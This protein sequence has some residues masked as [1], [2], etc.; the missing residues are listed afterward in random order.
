ML[1]RKRA[2]ARIVKWLR[3][4]RRR[5]CRNCRHF[6]EHYITGLNDQ[7]LFRLGY[8]QNRVYDCRLVEPDI[9]RRCEWFEEK[10]LDYT[11]TEFN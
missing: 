8:C 3:S 4:R 5:R 1:F 11:V 6:A 2:A 9:E 7:G 10:S